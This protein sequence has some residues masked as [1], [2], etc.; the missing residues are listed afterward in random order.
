MKFM[1]NKYLHSRN[2][3]DAQKYNPYN[4][5]SNVVKKLS[6]FWYIPLL[7]LLLFVFK[8]QVI[9]FGTIGF[10]ILSATLI[11]FYKRII[12]VSLG[13]ELITFYSIVLSMAFSPVIGIVFAITLLFA[14]VI[15]Q[16][17][18]C[19]FFLIKAGVYS[20][21]CLIAPSL[22]FLG[23]I[24]AGIVLVLLRNLIFSGL[25]LMKNP[26]RLAVDAPGIFI[27][28]TLGIFLFSEFGAQL[29]GVFS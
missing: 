8:E 23:I 2:K 3:I 27:N 5:N 13:L 21:L 12:P 4:K 24:N 9:F 1:E 10:M 22:L 7:T 25:T 20:L 14:E 29:L 16:N 11:S 15:I 6:K 26:G 18:F 19:G 17:N 28:I